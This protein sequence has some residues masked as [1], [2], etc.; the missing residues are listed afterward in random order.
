[1]EKKRNPIWKNKFIYALAA[2]VFLLSACKKEMPVNNTAISGLMAI[3]LIPDQPAVDLIM[4]GNYLT[5]SPLSYTNYTGTYLSVY[6]GNRTVALGLSNTDT[7]ISRTHFVFEPS[8]F[9]SVIAMGANGN[10][11]NL[12]LNDNIDSLA[13]G[14]GL[15][16]VRY[17][18][19]VPD[20]SKADISIAQNGNNVLNA[21]ASFATASDFKSVSP[22]DITV[23]AS[24]E[25]YSV[26]RT[27]SVEK[28]KVYTVMLAGIPEA[29]D[30]AKAVQIKYI[31]NGTVSANP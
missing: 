11:R 16:F 4:S 10:Y 7:T 15:A 31:V 8:R 25:N 21:N 5:N 12:V 22:G 20:S 14:S 29:T 19:A 28:D 13:T 24:G 23:T 30:T 6:S 2:T 9:Y 17:V 18:N 1:M 26:N 3:N 27:I